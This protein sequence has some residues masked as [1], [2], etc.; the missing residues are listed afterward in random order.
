MRFAIKHADKIVGLFVLLALIGVV[1]VVIALGANQHWFTRTVHFY[2]IFGSA[3]G[4]VRGMPITFKGF[5]IGRV[6]SF[7]LD[8]N[9]KVVVQYYIYDTF[10]PKVS[11]HSVVELTSSP[12]GSSMLFYPGKEKTEPLKEHSLIPSIDSDAGR[13]IVAAKLADTPEK[14]EDSIS[15]I[16]QNV[17]DIT[18]Q[19]DALVKNNAGELDT[20]IKSLSRS[21]AALA[22]AMEGKGSGPVSQTLVGLS[23]IVKNLNALTEDMNGLIPKLLDPTGQEVYPAIKKILSNIEAI[24]V[25]L[26]NFAN[27]ISGTQPQI[28]GILDQIPDVLSKG[29][30]VMEALSNNPLLSGGIT[31]ERE[32]PSTFKSFRDEAF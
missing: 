25:Q 28:S 2:S 15:A 30:D 12:L 22:Q 31:K 13:A 21:T 26:K 14:S 9:N 32:Q 10:Y 7:E 24:S 23:G 11:S 8:E 6:S 17:D 16:M 18:S 4:L 29:K 20:I 27:F 1:V 3:K 19:I 5:E